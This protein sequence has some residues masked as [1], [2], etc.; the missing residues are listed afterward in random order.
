MT[1]FFKWLVAVFILF[2]VSACGFHLRGQNLPPHIRSIKLESGT[3]YAE[4]ES[5]L[6]RHFIRRGINVTRTGWAPI[7]LHIINTKLTQDV[8]TI[9]GS[10]Q[11]RVYVYYYQVYFEILDANH[12]ILVS[13]RCITT[14]ET[15]IVNAGTALE[16]TNQL[17]ILKQEMQLDASR[18]IWN[19]LASPRLY[20]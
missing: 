1:I 8:P 14:S 20:S 15:L 2:L 13:S 6:R 11:A 7:I 18:I 5:T 4:F 10:N 12:A 19:V 17:E 9:G 3:P 16:S